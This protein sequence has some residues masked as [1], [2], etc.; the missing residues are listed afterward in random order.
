MTA[1]ATKSIKHMQ[2]SDESIHYSSSAFFL[3]RFAF[4]L[5]SSRTEVNSSSANPNSHHL[6]QIVQLP[7]RFAE[8]LGI[9]WAA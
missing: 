8:Q 7:A 6:A 3:F 1:T 9:D 2:A 4:F 5:V